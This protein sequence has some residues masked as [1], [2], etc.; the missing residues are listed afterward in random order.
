[1]RIG[2][3][4]AEQI[5]EMLLEGL[6]IST[7][8]RL[9][10]VKAHTIIDLMVL[11]GERCEKFLQENHRNLEVNS[12]QA[13]EIWGYVHC[14]KKTAIRLGYQD[15]PVGDAYCYTAMDPASKLLVCFH[16]GKWTQEHT[17]QFCRKL[18]YAVAGRFKLSTDGFHAYEPAVG[19][20]LFR[21]TDYGQVIESFG[22]RTVDEDRFH[23]SVP[24]II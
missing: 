22:N 18:G 2:L 17:D 21:R 14:K 10:K 20:H 16:F 8:S 11:V 12:I 13:D 1:M 6:S 15:K 5:I 4:K 24:G 7:V 9:T 19:R 23:F 3:E